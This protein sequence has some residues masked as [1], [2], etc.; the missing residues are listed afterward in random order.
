MNK[1]LLVILGVV[2]I[3]GLAIYLITM[4]SDDFATGNDQTSEDTTQNTDTNTIGSNANQNGT[5]NQRINTL[6]L[7]E[8]GGGNTVDIASVS[9]EEPGFIALYRMNSQSDV[10]FIGVSDFLPAGAYTDLQVQVDSIIVEDQ[11][12]VGVLYAD[13]GNG[14]FDAPE[15]D[16]YLNNNYEVVTDVDVVGMDF[17]DEPAE[18]LEQ[19]KDYVDSSTTTELYT[20]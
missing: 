10:Q 4:Q 9:L 14:E 7:A 8:N 5:T 20:E 13:D 2:L 3:G 6:V 18:I 17:A 15:S 12:V 1:T 19:A 11:I 16:Y